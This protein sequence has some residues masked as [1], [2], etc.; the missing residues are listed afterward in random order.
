[1]LSKEQAEVMLD[2]Q[3]SMNAKVDP[4]WVSARYP[5]LRAVVI[6]AAE[7]MEHHGWKWWK[8][9]DLDLPQLQM[10]LVDIWHFILSELLLENEG[11]LKPTLELLNKLLT[12]ASLQTEVV[13]T[14]ETYQLSELDLLAKLELLIA[15]SAMRKID[16]A[17]FAGIMDDCDIGWTELY[18]QY[19]GKNVLNFFRQDHGYK[20]G[21][22]K[23]M[24]NDRE[25]NEYLVDIMESLDATDPSFKDQLYTALENAYP[26]S[27][28]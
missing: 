6:E 22:Y 12:E 13:Q 9:Q 8:K 3:A 14:G 2:L 21:T 7:A 4:N 17:V 20:A 11:A 16:L 24:W 28:D 19:V 23:K 27:A 1:M 18:R 26:D 25:D 15:L 5:Y 10:E